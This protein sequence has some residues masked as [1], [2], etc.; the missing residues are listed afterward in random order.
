[1]RPSEGKG[2]LVVEKGSEQ[3]TLVQSLTT[4]CLP[5]AGRIESRTGILN[6][7]Y[8]I[9]DEYFADYQVL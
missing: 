3:N 1:M 9:T 7:S 5:V 8:G 4:Q 2:K 6:H